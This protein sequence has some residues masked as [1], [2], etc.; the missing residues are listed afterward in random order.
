M[1]KVSWEAL[2]FSDKI[3]LFNKWSIVSAAANLFSFFG[4]FFYMVSS[5]FKYFEVEGFIG[6]GC[7][8]T[9]F[10]ITRYFANTQDYTI[11]SRTFEMA[12]P[13]VVKVMIGGLPVFFGF[14]FL[15]V[16]LFWPMRGYF[17]NVPNSAYVL[18]G[19]MNGD[20]VGDVF[21]GTT[22]SRLVSG[23]IFCYVYVILGMCYIQNLNMICVEDCYLTAKYM[24]NFT[25]LTGDGK[26]KDQDKSENEEREGLRPEQNN[27][28]IVRLILEK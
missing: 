24:S 14:V 25:W 27:W 6:L 5:L 7:C 16:C 1:K 12:I 8:L 28:N 26:N 9:W 22:F 3:N 18:F 20:S 10:S 13:L 15:G 4:C 19:V 23:Q 11:I 21:T 2:T 17:D